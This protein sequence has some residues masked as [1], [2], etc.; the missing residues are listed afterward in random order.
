M[1][2]QSRRKALTVIEIHEDAAWNVVAPGLVPELLERDG[3]AVMARDERNILRPG[4]PAV[5]HRHRS[6]RGI[7]SFAATAWLPR[8]VAATS[9]NRLWTFRSFPLR[10]FMICRQGAYPA[11]RSGEPDYAANGAIR[12]LAS[13]IVSNSLIVASAAST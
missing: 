1:V 10:T 2:A 6:G 8:R 4:R 11:S 7:L 13:S 5:H 12:S 3:A 9:R